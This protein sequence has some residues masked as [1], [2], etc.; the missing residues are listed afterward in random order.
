LTPSPGFLS[1]WRLSWDG[2]VAAIDYPLRKA[3]T[4]L[5]IAEKMSALREKDP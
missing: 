3:A 2:L 5:A 4:E 1:F